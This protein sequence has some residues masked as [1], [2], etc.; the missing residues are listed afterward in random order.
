VIL[1]KTI[2]IIKKK[3]P[4]AVAVDYDV[5][6]F[7]KRVYYVYMDDDVVHEETGISLNMFEMGEE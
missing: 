1:I 4:N 7:G 5:R 3:Y 6:N 2:D